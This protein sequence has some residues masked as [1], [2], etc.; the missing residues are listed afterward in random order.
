MPVGNSYRQSYF[1]F[2]NDDGSETN[3]TW[4]A[5]ENTDANIALDT[6]FRVRISIYS[7]G[8]VS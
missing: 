7:G 2:R 3:A 4:I 5:A 1:R 8:A 6:N